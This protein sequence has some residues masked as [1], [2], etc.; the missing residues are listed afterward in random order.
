MC[1]NG[2]SAF[3]RQESEAKSS[4]YI[5][6]LPKNPT[7]LACEIIHPKIDL[8]EARHLEYI[9]ETKFLYGNNNVNVL[10][11]DNNPYDYNSS[12]TRP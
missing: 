2:R 8:E 5:I 11:L 3:L 6:N 1:E 12:D 10:Y 7:Y 9:K 4:T